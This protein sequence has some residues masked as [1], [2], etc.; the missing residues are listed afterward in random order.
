M[1]TTHFNKVTRPASIYAGCSGLLPNPT[2]GQVVLQQSSV[3]AHKKIRADK[4][5]L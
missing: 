4:L 5:K 2:K 3:F 1:Y